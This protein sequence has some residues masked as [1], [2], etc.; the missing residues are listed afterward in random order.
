VNDLELEQR[1]R[2]AVAE[3]PPL[4]FDPD[5]LVDTA[6]H[7]QRRRRAVLGSVAAVVVV[8]GSAIA[9]TGTPDIATDGRR[10]PVAESADPPADPEAYL[11]LRGEEMTEYL[12]QR[13]P[14]VVPGAT[15][16]RVEDWEV[17]EVQVGNR[18]WGELREGKAGTTVRFTLTGSRK[19]LF[20]HVAGSWPGPLDGTCREIADGGQLDGCDVD[21]RPDGSRLVVI[22]HSDADSTGLKVDHVRANDERVHFSTFAKAGEPRLTETQ[23]TELATDPK[24]GVYE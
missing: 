21:T 17:H 7:R 15:K 8:A 14:Q 9:L 23:L 19:V 12:Q 10:L 20:V 5:R 11:L 1:M 6:V 16:I 3:A 24:F 13:L 2:T 18:S 4:S 22:A